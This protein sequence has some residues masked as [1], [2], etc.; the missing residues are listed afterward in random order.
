M[1]PKRESEIWAIS[2]RFGSLEFRNLL[3]LCSIKFRAKR[4]L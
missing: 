2:G 4:M 3:Y 1:L